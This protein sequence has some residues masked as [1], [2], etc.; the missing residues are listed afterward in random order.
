MKNTWV[1]ILLLTALAPGCQNDGVTP[2]PGKGQISFSLASGGQDGSG[3]RISGDVTPAA[4][5]LS[6]EGQ[7]G[8]P[9]AQAKKLSIW[10]M[11]DGYISESIELVVGTYKLTQ[12]FVLSATDEIIYASPVEGSPMAQYVTQPLPLIFDVAENTNTQVTP[13]VLAVLPTD[14][15]AAF[16]YANFGFEIIEIPDQTPKLVEIWHDEPSDIHY[17]TKFTYSGDLPIKQTT[18][19]FWSNAWETLDSAVFQYDSEGKLIAKNSYSVFGLPDGQQPTESSTTYEYY[20][21]GNLKKMITKGYDGSNDH[22]FD[23]FYDV[24]GKLTHA[25]QKFYP[26]LSMRHQIKYEWNDD[27]DV[28]NVKYYNATGTDLMFEFNYTY[29]SSVPPLPSLFDHAFDPHN[30]SGAHNIA[31]QET[32]GYN[33]TPGGIVTSYSCQFSMLYELTDNQVSKVM[34]FNPDACFEADADQTQYTYLYK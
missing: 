22:E 28:T 14:S 26:S 10:L 8:K 18:Y 15:P 27:G 32:I 34:V 33:K 24:A 1:L 4:I 16:G 3:G 31:T 19:Y 9:V 6:I 20:G 30:M 21:D 5:L 17:K 2:A 25:D 13:Q 7:D 12:F 23:F 11:G 29:D